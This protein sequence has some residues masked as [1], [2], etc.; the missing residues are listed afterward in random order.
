[1]S[2]IIMLISTLLV[3]YAIRIFAGAELIQVQV[4]SLK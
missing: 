4:I 3:N 2:H 1:M